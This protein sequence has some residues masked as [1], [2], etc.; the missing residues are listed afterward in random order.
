L[1]ITFVPLTVSVM[2]AGAHF[3][4]TNEVVPEDL[5]TVVAVDLPDEPELRELLVPPE[6]P[7]A[8]TSNGI[9]GPIP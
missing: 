4:P 2:P 7:V 6:V 8:Q 3:F 1:Q 5:A 9:I